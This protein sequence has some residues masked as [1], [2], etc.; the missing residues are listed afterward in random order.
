LA[1]GDA[2]MDQSALCQKQTFRAAERTSLFD[3]FVGTADCHAGGR[4]G[5][6]FRM[7]L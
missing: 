4:S 6:S 3:H 5:H 7:C 1:G 2:D